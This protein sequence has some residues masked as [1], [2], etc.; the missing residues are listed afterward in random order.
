MTQHNKSFGSYGEKLAAEFL[1]KKGYSILERNFRNKFG[2]MDLITQDG[3][4]ICFTEVKCRKSLACGTPLEAVHYYKQRN[5]IRLAQSYLKFRYGTPDV[6]A[7]F[8]V[9]SIYQDAAGVNQIEHIVNAFE[10]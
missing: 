2:E 3:K 10:C 9:I 6:L 8:D 4:V 1:E 7:R 5:L